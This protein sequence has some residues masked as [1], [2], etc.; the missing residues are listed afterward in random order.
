VKEEDISVVLIGIR[1]SEVWH[2]CIEDEVI[3]C[4]HSASLKILS[5]QLVQGRGTRNLLSFRE[6]IT[7]LAQWILRHCCGLGWSEVHQHRVALAGSL[8]LRH[9][10]V[11]F[12]QPD[13]RRSPQ[14]L[15]VDE[16]QGCCIHFHTVQHRATQ[17]LTA[18][19]QADSQLVEMRADEG[20]MGVV[21][22][23]AASLL[24][25]LLQL[26]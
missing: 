2:S 6:G 16:L 22:V 26:G 10:E 5:A 18:G 14:Q 9:V 7:Q 21:L 13:S 19:A 11:D 15:H 3:S 4:L 12:L 8:I 23:E 1:D 25:P 17:C 20:A 24:L